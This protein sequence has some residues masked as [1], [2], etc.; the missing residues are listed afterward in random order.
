MLSQLR[1]KNDHENTGTSVNIKQLLIEVSQEYSLEV[2]H[3]LAHQDSYIF[4]DGDKFLNVLCHLIQNS[5]EAAGKNGKVELHLIQ[6]EASCSI[7]VVDTG[8]GMSDDFIRTR[9]FK[10]F[11][12]TK[13]NAGMGIGAYEAKYFIESIGGDVVVSSVV[14]QGT[15]IIMTIPIVT[16]DG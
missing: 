8:C 10:P 5:L 12:T 7:S 1:K 2:E 16:N 3:L 6:H 13:G 15:S 4:I 9:L 14:N 11:D